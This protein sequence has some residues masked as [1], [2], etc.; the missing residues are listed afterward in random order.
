MILRKDEE[1]KMDWAGGEGGSSR[2]HGIP[3]GNWHHLVYG[4]RSGDDLESIWTNREGWQQELSA[5]LACMMR[6]KDGQK[7]RDILQQ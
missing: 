3:D 4:V 1:A 7:S 6:W 2:A 5:F